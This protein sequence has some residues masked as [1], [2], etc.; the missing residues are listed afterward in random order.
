MAAGHERREAP[1]ARWPWPARWPAR[2]FALLPALLPLAALG[3]AGAALDAGAAAQDIPPPPALKATPGAD[4]ELYL[5]VTLNGQ[6]TGSI[7]RF[8]K[9]KGGLRS[10]VDNL[11]QL[12]LE[13]ARFG[14]A[15]QVDFALDLVDGLSYE[16]DATRQ[17]ISLRVADALRAP[18]DVNARSIQRAPPATVTPGVVFNY[19]AYTLFG[20]QAST[21]VFNELRYFNSAGVFSSTGT[22]TVSGRDKQY[23]RYDTFWM[24]TDADALTAFTAGD[25]ISSS[26]SWSR[27]VRLGGVQWRKNFALRP[28]LL[29]FPVASLGGSAVVPS[30]LS[31][32]VNGVQ[33]YN[34]QV[35]SGPFV[36]NQVAGLNGAGQATVVTRDALG[37]AVSTTLPLYVD[38]RMLAPGLI[39]Y[40]YELGVLRR[41]YGARSFGY[42][43]TPV[44]SASYRY[45]GSDVLTLEAHG[46]VSAGLLNGG[47]GLFYRFGQYGVLNA[48]L[49]GSAG[50]LAGLQGGLGYRYISGRYSVEVQTLRASPRYGDLAARDGSAVTAAADRLSLSVALPHSQSVSLSYV[51]FRTGALPASAALPPRDQPQQSVARIAS[52]SYSASL[53]NEMFLSVSGFQ[54]FKRRDDRGFFVSLSMAFGDRTTAGINAGRQNGSANRSLNLARTPDFGG[55]F[56]WGLQDGQQGDAHYQTAQGQYLGT[57]GQVTGVTQSSGGRRTSSLDVAGALV[58]MDGSVAAARQAGAGFALVSTG[59]VANIPVIHENRQ[60]GVTDGGG[61]FLVPNLNP[62]ANNQI[63]IDISELPV[64][65]RVRNAQLNVVPKSLSGVLA[66]FAVERYSAAT[67]ILHDANGKVLDTGLAVLHVESGGRTVVGFDGVAFIDDL[68]A[69]NHVL[70]GAGAAQC[71]VRFAYRRPADGSL[72]VLGPLVCQ[73]VPGGH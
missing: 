22:A 36:I 69:D 51:G 4:E 32:Y 35:P 20:Q 30:A 47:A 48:T 66:N 52:L 7:L 57:Y 65:A 5:E 71:Q 18:Y 55:G 59:G 9:N 38:T 28:D 11:Q 25:L 73:A 12:G 58:F 2:R 15:G 54:D 63:G 17:S 13:P 10:S 50:Q 21:S 37:R 29:T 34:T 19:D 68:A 70:V 3:L 42:Q 33:Q 8:S 64:D 60:I 27:A 16:Y 24:Q 46:E 49:A 56:G 6:P 39:D 26:L 53:G 45:G 23:L 43:H 31:L 72:P 61:H 44:A 1:G 62:Y 40:S 14:V 41:D 67:L